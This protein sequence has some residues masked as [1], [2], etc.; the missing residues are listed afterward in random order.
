MVPQQ[1]IVRRYTGFACRIRAL[2]THM[3]HTQ[4]GVREGAKKDDK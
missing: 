3:K 4:I 2:L 1:G